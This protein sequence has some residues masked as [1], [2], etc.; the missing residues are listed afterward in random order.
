V[1]AQ[2]RTLAGGASP[3]H[4]LEHRELK[5]STPHMPTVKL[6]TAATAATST[7]AGQLPFV[8]LTVCNTG[9]RQ[10]VPY[11]LEWIEAHV[12]LGFQ[13][14]IIVED[15]R[16]REGYSRLMQIYANRSD[17]HVIVVP[18]SSIKGFFINDA[19]IGTPRQ[20]PA[21][22]MCLEQFGNFTRWMGIWD[23]DEYPAPVNPN[24]SLVDVLERIDK[25]GGSTG[26]IY[27]PP[28]RFGTAGQQDRFNYTLTYDN[29]GRPAYRNPCGVQL[30]TA[31]HIWRQPHPW[32]NKSEEAIKKELMTRVDCK[33]DDRCAT[34]LGK[35][36]SRPA[37]LNFTTCLEKGAIH[38]AWPLR[39]GQTHAQMDTELRLVH[40][41]YRSKQDVIN[42]TKQHKIDHVGKAMPVMDL[43]DAVRDTLLWDRIGK[44]LV[45]RVR[46]MITED[47]GKPQ[48][49]PGKDD[50]ETPRIDLAASLL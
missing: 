48:P 28:A 27:M 2:T 19:E 38:Y 12:L 20:R 49:T 6:S 11:L 34:G 40:Y 14:F 25:R 9:V 43:F 36:I 24:E 33:N 47:G 3:E 46:K 21:I 26:S 35:S 17:A 31:R 15:T 42:K 23:T 37:A 4:E 32:I 45:E 5:I 44:Q 39:G 29:L 7:A 10:E 41:A 22:M 30:L 18:G 50:C 1:R 13:R 16:S 8:N